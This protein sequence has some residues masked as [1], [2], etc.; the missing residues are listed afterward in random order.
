MGASRDDEGLASSPKGLRTWKPD[1]MPAQV[2]AAAKDLFDSVRPTEL[3]VL[4]FDSVVDE[5]EAAEKHTLQFVHDHTDIHLYVCSGG[6]STVIQGVLDRPGAT[7]AVL[8]FR[9]TERSVRAPVEGTT[10]ELVVPGHG[11]ARLTLEHDSGPD[12]R[13]DWLRI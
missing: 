7:W 6:D 11:T 5:A 12:I 8:Q 2:A 3:A 9:E 1:P 4:V 10:F 13:T